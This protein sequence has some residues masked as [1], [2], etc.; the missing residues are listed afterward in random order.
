[1]FYCCLFHCFSFY[2]FPTHISL[3]LYV[4]VL[5]KPDPWTASS[6]ADF[7]CV[8]L[9]PGLQ[10]VL[11]MDFYSVILVFISVPLP[12]CA[13]TSAPQ[14]LHQLCQKLWKS[15]NLSLCRGSARCW[16][17]VESFVDNQQSGLTCSLLGTSLQPGPE[18]CAHFTCLF[19]LTQPEL[20]RLG[21]CLTAS[22]IRV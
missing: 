9:P 10:N 7:G 21:T 15:G 22:W 13:F 8:D 12:T 11:L 1:M 4:S 16:D 14:I 5:S 19:N 18:V 6:L 17:A 2:Y 3:I 20:L